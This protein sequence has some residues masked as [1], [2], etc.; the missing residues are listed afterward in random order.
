ME[1]IWETMQQLERELN[2]ANAERDKA[3]R[4]LFDLTYTMPSGSRCTRAWIAAEQFLQGR[5]KQEG[6]E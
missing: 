3:V 5:Q 1:P 6:G 2:E 4:L